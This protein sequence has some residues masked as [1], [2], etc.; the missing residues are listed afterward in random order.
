M[1]HPG[2]D[3]PRSHGPIERWMHRVLLLL[4]F[5]LWTVAFARQFPS[6]AWIGGADWAEPTLLI[7]ALMVTVSSVT[8]TLPLQNA[9]M[10][11]GVIAL[12]GGA[13]H[14]IS[15][16]ASVPFGPIRFPEARGSSPFQECF[17][18]MA[19]LWVV[20]L[21]NARG[22]AHVILERRRKHRNHGLHVI[23]LSAALAVFMALT[24]EPFASR[25][26]HYWFWGATRLPFDWQ[27]VPLSALFAWG[28]VSVIALIAATPA[29]IDKHPRPTPMTT[30][31]LW[32]WAMMGGLFAAGTA[33]AGLWAPTGVAIANVLL[34]L[35]LAVVVNRRRM[36][37]HT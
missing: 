7:V 20:L 33:V 35:A 18:A 24:L 5:L 32:L 26:H 4:L 31:P 15:H 21:S 1:F 36:S 6:I 2:F 3:R 22:V 34:A 28:V 16:V 11:A 12:G 17:C 25:A 37:R 30:D 8:H 10:A 27:G 9:L 14:W 23:G 19:V 13:A 29:L